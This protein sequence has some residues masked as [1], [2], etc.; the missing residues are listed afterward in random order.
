MA[1]EILDTPKEGMIMTTK[2]SIS[3][4]LK[5]DFID[6]QAILN[7][8]I[9]SFEGFVS[10]EIVSPK[11]DTWMIVQRFSNS[12]C[13]STWSQS[14]EC[15]GLME[16][17]KLLLS[18]D[19]S[20]SIQE[21]ESMTQEPQ[22]E[23]IEVFVAQVARGKEKAYRDWIAK[24]HHMEAKFPG[25]R[26]AYVQ[27]PGQEGRSLNWITLLKFDTPTNL[28]KWLSSP[29]RKEILRE[30]K[31][32][33]ASL[34]SHR[35]ISPYAGWFSSFAE[36]GEIIPV[37]KQ[38]MVVLLVLFPIVVFE[39]K[40]LSL[41]TSPLKPSL[42]TFIGNAISVILISW[43]MMPITIWFLGW[44]LS[45]KGE[46]KELTT[47]LGTGLMFLLYSIEVALFWNFL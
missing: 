22:G 15:K 8:K 19:S 46:R 17:L 42:G 4:S 6:W 34:E 28:D 30:S 2:V 40:Y 39:M 41:L 37:W 14:A 44:W 5:D 24:I 47:L 45:P 43:P 38:T 36:V 23:V 1:T 35:V 18:K 25:F 7:K 16:E 33:L 13:L 27:A 21:Q 31:P 12:A 9:A 11:E 32:L 29:E 20:A 26:G 10:L 3:S